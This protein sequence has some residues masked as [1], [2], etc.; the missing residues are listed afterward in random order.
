M[1]AVLDKNTN[2]GNRG[3]H[4]N[5]GSE[6]LYYVN[7]TLRE[8]Y[9]QPVNPSTPLLRQVAKPLVSGMLHNLDQAGGAAGDLKWNGPV[10]KTLQGQG[11]A[12]LFKLTGFT[13]LDQ[14]SAETLTSVAW[15]PIGPN[16]NVPNEDG[17]SVV[18]NFYAVQIP[19]L[20]GDPHYAKV[21]VFQDSGVK[22]EWASYIAGTQ[23]LYVYSLPSLH[24]S[25]RNLVMSAF[26]SELYVSGGGSSNG[27]VVKAPR[28]ASG[29]YPT[30]SPQPI[31]LNPS[32][33]DTPQQM[34]VD[35]GSIYVV[36][37]DGL[38]LI[39]PE[40]GI[41]DQV[42]SGIP[43]PYGLLLDQQGAIT[44]AYISN[45]AGKIFAVDISGFTSSSFDNDGLPVPSS[46][47]IT[48]S[49]IKYSLAGPAGYLSWADEAH[50][51]FYAPVV[52]AAGQ[53]KRMDLSTSTLGD[54][55][56][57]ADPTVPSPWSVQVFT[58]NSMTAIC[59]ASIYDIERGIIVSSDLALG[60]GLIPFDYINESK[61]NPTVPAADGGRADT[62][63]VPGYYFS[64]NPDL[65]FGGSLSLLINH[66]AA[67]ASNLRYYRVSLTNDANLVTRTINNEFVDLKW[68]A[69]DSKFLSVSTNV[70]SG[71]QRFAV[72]DPADLWYNPFLGA[73][74]NTTLAD[75]GYNRLKVEFFQ[76][77]TAA[78][79]TQTY[80]RL[81][82]LDNTKSSATL[83]YMRR[84][85]PTVPPLPGSANYQIPDVCGLTPYDS[86]DDLIEFDF[87]AVHPSGVGTYSI[88]FYR[89]STHLFSV[90]GN[91]TANLTLMTIKE[92]SAG[93]PLRIGHLSGNCDIAN[94]SVNISVASKG[95][96][97]GYG[98]VNLGAS[99]SR[100]FTLAKP[101]LTHTPW[102]LA[103]ITAGGKK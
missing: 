92:R 90:G 55:L 24:P 60:I 33:L 76:T 75:N 42:V 71:T 52:G 21:R 2:A 103:P 25:P 78:L 65:A 19:V 95:V 100:S 88:G 93:V 74:F 7:E 84:G 41:Q 61:L 46:G 59:D 14:I 62:S 63:S 72:R 23:P 68:S 87:S 98:W 67:W 97:N 40:L 99:I 29:P 18:G 44:M 48:A 10:V 6:F 39:K 85:T 66:D 101:P 58:D 16:T 54:E 94:I 37:G 83:N 69:V 26:D 31:T 9:R 45:A 51:A 96:I 13:S 8:V 34:V 22:I 17:L 4:F 70:Q 35:G 11:S 49:T 73:I 56:S 1:T 50:T 86:K 43:S 57:S 36:A 77:S 28:T 64:A 27:Y 3:S 80:S 5:K 81:L 79:P 15:G 89:G 102:P 12:K 82:F 47:A 53:L 91:L 30:Y 38:F 32:P 20:G